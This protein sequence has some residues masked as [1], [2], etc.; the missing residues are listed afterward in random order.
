MKDRICGYIDTFPTR[1]TKKTIMQY[2]A[3]RR[4]IV[5]GPRK[6]LYDPNYTP[7]WIE[8]A[9]NM[10]VVSPINKTISVK[11]VQSGSTTAME[12]GINYYIEEEPA[13]QL[14]LS[15]TQDLLK[16][17]VETNL[18]PSIRNFGN[19]EHIKIIDQGKNKKKTGDLNFRKAY[20]GCFLDMVSARSSSSLRQLTKQINWL[21][22]IDAAPRALVSGEGSFLKV[23]EGRVSSFGMRGKTYITSTPTTSDSAIWGEFLK[24][25]RRYFMVPCPTCGV[26]QALEF[27]NDYSEFGLKGTIDDN[28]RVVECYYL[29]RE[30]GHQIDSSKKNMMLAEGFWKS[31]AV[32]ESEYTRSY[33]INSLY[34][35]IGMGFDWPVLFKMWKNAE[36]AS[37]KLDI[38]SFTNLYMGLPYEDDGETIETDDI[39]YMQSGY[40]AMEVPEG[41]LF[42][43]AGLDVQKGSKKDKKNPPR[44]EMEIVGH[45]WSYKTWGFQ[46]KVFYG[47]VMDPFSGAWQQLYEFCVNTNMSFIGLNGARYNCVMSLVDSGDYS[48]TGAGTGIVYAF[49]KRLKNFFPSKGFRKLKKRT[50]DRYESDIRGEVDKVRNRVVNIGTDNKLIEISTVHY[51]DTLYSR[52]QIPRVNGSNQSSG[53]CDFPS[54]YPRSYFDMLTSETKNLEDGSYSAHGRRNEALDCRIYAMAAADVYL[55]KMVDKV[56]KNLVKGGS[57]PDVVEKKIRTPFILKAIEN[58]IKKQLVT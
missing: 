9:D 8:P 38:I 46:Y 25:D 19:D 52:L 37:D 16:R 12:N 44:I 53:F 33:S 48:N 15:G 11:S 45:G 21:D 54:D 23:V 41:V 36:S 35:P 43:T 42:L 7:F 56:R 17:W 24:G 5:T 14:Y 49:C 13:D 47:D 28:N 26:F 34:S 4:R 57:N 32:S 50:G 6:G 2:S 22:E 18:D 58:E 40:K 55:E 30:C 39:I 31:T 1:R 51:K 20:F 27:G 3:G 10:S 29:C